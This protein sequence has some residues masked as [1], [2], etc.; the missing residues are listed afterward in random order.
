MGP[1]TYANFIVWTLD[2]AG[3]QTNLLV[4][5]I[6]AFDGYD[7]I[8]LN[9]GESTYRLQISAKGKWTV[10]ILPLAP[11]YMHM[12]QLPGQY[13]GNG[14]D[15]VFLSGNPDLATFNYAG[16]R[17]FIVWSDGQSGR[18]LLVNTVGAYNGTVPVPP[19]TVILEISSDM[20]WSMSVTAR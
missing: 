2:Q 8:D 19:G 13:N 3:N 5:T 18:D 16:E 12:L 10:D 1:S 17:N 14:P 20:K 4:N 6:G 9:E 11:Q 7:L 15:V